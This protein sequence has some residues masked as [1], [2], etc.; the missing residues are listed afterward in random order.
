[1]IIARALYG[2]K[3]SGAVWR[4]KLAETLISLGY[5]SSKADADVWMKQDFKTNGYPYYK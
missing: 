1:M 5:K 2:P 4:E 3:S